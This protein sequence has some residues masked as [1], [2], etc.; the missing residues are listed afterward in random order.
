[1]RDR[2][3]RSDL[4]K[5][6]AFTHCSRHVFAQASLCKP[7][8]QG[9]AESGFIP[10]CAF[11]C[12]FSL[13]QCN[14]THCRANSP[15]GCRLRLIAPTPAGAGGRAVCAG[16]CGDAFHIRLFQVG[17]KKSD[18]RRNSIGR[19]LRL[20]YRMVF[21]VP[22]FSTPFHTANTRSDLSTIYILRFC[23]QPGK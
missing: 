18:R 17:S 9:K 5:R 21:Q 12:V 3:G 10:V 15:C 16:G 7:R 1:M 4:C 13:S 20:A 11:L 19:V 8:Q 23:S 6:F 2:S 22:P 14:A